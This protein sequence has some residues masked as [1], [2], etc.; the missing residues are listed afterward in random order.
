M[1]GLDAQKLAILDLLG[2]QYGFHLG[3]ANEC[4]TLSGSA[5]DDGREWSRCGWGYGDS[6]DEMDDDDLDFAEVSDREMTI[7]NLVDLEGRKLQEQLDFDEES[8]VIPD[9]LMEDVEN[10]AH[11]GQDYEGYMGNVSATVEF[12]LM[13]Y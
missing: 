8:E 4:C 10:G 7:K 13:C 3:L 6:E 11:D 2:K 1:K 9:D 5:D 12:R